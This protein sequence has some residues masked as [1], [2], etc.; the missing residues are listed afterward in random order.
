LAR[1]GN[2]EAENLRRALQATFA[3]R[4]THSLPPRLSDL[5]ASWERSFRRLAEQTG[6]EYLTLEEASHAIRRFIDPILGEQ[7][8]GKWNPLLWQWE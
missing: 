3:A 2:L 4:N 5:P 7:A 6:L 8:V 1:W